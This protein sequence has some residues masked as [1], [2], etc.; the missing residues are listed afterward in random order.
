MGDEME[1]GDEE[2]S[3]VAILNG[4]SRASHKGAYP[5]SCGSIVDLK[6]HRATF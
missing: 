3:P 2:K 6:Q 5:V 1:E 4:K